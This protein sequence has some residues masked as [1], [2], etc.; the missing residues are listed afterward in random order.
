[1][2]AIISCR[3]SGGIRVTFL[4][5]GCASAIAILFVAGAIARG[6]DPAAAAAPQQLAPV[7][8]LPLSQL[9]NPATPSPAVSPA[10]QIPEA[11]RQ[12][13][14]ATAG[15]GDEQAVQAAVK[16][17][18]S[19]LKSPPPD[20][21]PPPE[22]TQPAAP[23]EPSPPKPL[24]A[25]V[26]APQ[27]VA[28]QLAA[29]RDLSDLAALTPLAVD[30]AA[31]KGITPGISTA[32]EL[33]K[34]WGD[35]IAA[36]S[37]DGA[38][39]RIYKIDPYRRVEVTLLNDKV[40]SIAVQ[41]DKPFEP[42]VLAKQLKLDKL[43]AVTVPDDMGQPLGQS[44]PERGILLSFA[45]ETKLVTQMLLE[46][47]DAE[48][49]ILRAE[50]QAD[51]HTRSSLQDIDYALRLEPKSSKAHAI[52]GR[53]FGSI[54]RFDDA[55]AEIEESLRLDAAQ[56]RVLLMKAD[57]LARRSQHAE[58]IAIVKSVIDEATTQPVVKAMAFDAL[59]DLAAGGPEHDYK[60][61]IELHLSAIKAAQPLAAER[62]PDVRREA[63]R[64]LVEAHLGAA[65]DIGL[66]VWQQKDQ[67]AAR[68]I[69][70]AGEM[71][72]DLIQNEQADPSLRLHVARRA[73]DARVGIQGKWDPSDWTAKAL[74]EG[75]K[76]II[77]C[78]DPLRAERLQWEL[79]LALFDI[80]Q[81]DQ[82][83]GLTDHSLADSKITLKFL[84]EGSQ[85]R[86]QTADES[87]L[88]GRMYAHLGVVEATQQKNHKRAVAWFD[89]ATPLLDRPLPPIAGDQLGRH[90][91]LFV[92]MGISYWETGRRDEALRLTQKGSDI[93]AK[94][95]ED[96]LLDE[97]AMAIPY[98]NLAAMHRELG[99]FEEAKNLAETAMKLD[100]T[101]K[102]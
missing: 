27:P 26:A 53:I 9:P 49:F 32:D 96:K 71:A 60:A 100:G 13:A 46:P 48:P 80:S 4:L 57:L 42:D 81:L 44:I 47:I 19:T 98:G 7:D 77:T 70:R 6:D 12:A 101:R 87:Y 37:K 35:G 2:S 102:Q 34:L 24:A 58:A 93:M 59:G 64:V 54:G 22:A 5:I 15:D 94:A 10:V 63:K 39:H 83:H 17:A 66:G 92:S 41:L 3:R 72:K 18:I 31:F 23:P 90:G 36:P 69:N 91:E 86:Q 68:W 25:S 38:T 95:V 8:S 55:L 20:K 67:T 14:G 73:L 40:T 79:G 11:P 85:H 84:E 21:S 45:P 28:N 99:H 56:P 76:I 29:P 78:D 33:Q 50:A 74:E 52:K 97:K 65:C 88:L 1:M 51:L 43:V 30:Q 62:R 16:E 61:A 82:F 75:Q 89:K